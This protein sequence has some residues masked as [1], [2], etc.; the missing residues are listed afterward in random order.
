MPRSPVPPGLKALLAA[1]DGRLD[2]AERWVGLAVR[3]APRGWTLAVRGMLAAR[4]GELTA[5]RR[6]LD[7]ALP[8]ENSPWA[9]LERA[10]VARQMGEFW[11]ALKDLELISSWLPSDPEPALRAA[12]VHLD[13]AQYPQALAC[14]DRVLRLTPRDASVYRRRARVHFV[15]GDAAAALAD[16]KQAFALAPSDVY[17][18]QELA[19][20]HLL[21]G[22]ERAALALLDG[23][24]LPAGSRDFW[25]GYR[26]CRRRR[27]AE[28]RKRFEAAAAAA[29]G[30]ADDMAEQ[31][32]LFAWVARSLEGFK[33]WPKSQ[34]AEVVLIGLGYKQLKQMT[35]ESL[36]ALASCD[37]LYCNHSD[38]KVAD[39]LGLFAAPH[40][41]IVF[42]GLPEQ[43]R[44]ASARVLSG[45][46]RGR[47]VGMVTRGQ[48]LVYGLL[49]YRIVE[50]CRRRGIRCR[51]SSS[52][53]IFDVLPALAPDRADP[54]GLQVRDSFMLEK[55]D[56][57]S[58]LIVYM[59][60]AGRDRGTLERALL[61]VYGPAHPCHLFA[62][63]GDREFQPATFPLSG[64]R[65]ALS[66]ADQACTLYLPRRVAVLRASA[67][68]P[69]ESRVGGARLSFAVDPRLEL[70]AVVDLLAARRGCRQGFRADGSGYAR[71]ILSRFA[72]FERHPVV[73][74]YLASC[75]HGLDAPTAAV[76]MLHCASASDLSPSLEEHPWAGYRPESP[77]ERSLPALLRAMERFSKESRFEEFFQEQA[78]FFERC[79]SQAERAAAGR[80]FIAR[81][82]EYTGHRFSAHYRVFLSPLIAA[83]V[84]HVH[85]EWEVFSVLAPERRG[86]KL[87]FGFL[88]PWKLWHELGRTVM[89][90]LAGAH[91]KE[92]SRSK[93]LWPVV[94]PVC[95]GM[96]SWQHCVA[97]HVAQCVAWRLRRQA[98]RAGGLP[99][100]KRSALKYAPY[101]G[102]VLSRLEEYEKDRKRYP[103][104]ESFYPR[105]VD[106]FTKLA[107]KEAA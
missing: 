46:A 14:L 82:E 81:L 56:A 80:P 41:G 89:D 69:A 88:D 66:T 65:E 15:K 54:G 92:I 60:L 25:L 38:P 71:R 33:P 37:L 29:R 22:D 45:A 95:E 16:L 76:L 10:A 83:P 61:D 34:D 2:E 59:P 9:R 1:R 98:P 70:L 39:F 8:E 91:A 68:G 78:P 62:G 93:R 90:R 63:G 18:A 36:Q 55:L 104:L 85:G 103:T 4:R 100:L 19:Q 23:L 7:A 32:S 107:A 40:E 101:A 6:D 79:R 3:R 51:V 64:L 74:A 96:A 106:V 31:A 73:D 105:L 58:P 28:A 17:L 49:A 94:S 42:R 35:L 50:G 13:Q 47:R 97:E 11:V 20:A 5:A 86:L 77:R 99:G 102:P 27:Y 87:A 21:R 24:E 12:A 52:V 48:P 75:A 67:A 72:A 26:D 84:N 53:S 30:R 43:A 57:G 44:T